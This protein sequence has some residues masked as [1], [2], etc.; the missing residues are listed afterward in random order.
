VRKLLLGLLFLVLVAPASSNM[1]SVGLGEVVLQSHLDEALRAEVPIRGA[2]AA[3]DSLRIEQASPE[4]YSR[5][6]LDRSRVPSDLN[7]EI[8]GEGADRRVVLT[9]RQAVNEPYIGILLEARWDGGRT[10]RELSLLLDPP[11]TLTAE[12][13]A[14]VV[15]EAP[16]APRDAGPAEGEVYRVRRG[17]T[18]ARVVQRMGMSGVSDDQAMIALLEHNPQ[19]FAHNNVNNLLAGAE[20]RVPP[21]S[22]LE[23]RSA[24]EARAEVAAQTE[25]WR[26]RI[27]AAREEEA[28]TEEADAEVAA[29]DEPEP[30]AEDDPADV[31]SEDVASEEAAEVAGHDVNGDASEETLAD[32]TEEPVEDRLEIVTELMPDEEAG[33]D[34][35]ASSADLL[36]ESLLSQQAEMEGLRDEIASLQEELGEREQLVEVA[37]QDLAELEDQLRQVRAEREEM[38]ARLERAEQTHNAPLHQRIT[39]DPLVMMMSVALVVLLVLAVLAFVRGGRREVVVDDRAVAPIVPV[40]GNNDSGSDDRG[41]PSGGGPSGGGAAGGVAGAAAAAGVAGAAAAVE[42][43]GEAEPKI[44]GDAAAGTEAAADATAETMAADVLA[45]VD[46]CLAY[47]M[48]DQAEEILTQNIEQDPDNHQYRLKLVEARVNLGDADGARAAAGELRER[49]GADD[50]ETRD[51]LAELETRI[52]GG[53]GDGATDGGSDAADAEAE[54]V[55][56]SGL[57]LPGASE[58]MSAAGSDA[59]TADASGDQGMQFDVDDGLD[60]ELARAAASAE[61]GSGPAQDD[62]P[63]ELAFNLDE[64][65]E[66]ELARAAASTEQGSGSAEGDAAGELAFDIDEGLDE[67]LAQA[68]A[69]TGAQQADSS[70]AGALDDLSFDL[71]DSDLPD[72]DAPKAG[73]SEAAGDDIPSLDLDDAAAFDA[74][75][76]AG[77]EGDDALDDDDNQ[78]KLSLA[79]A[80]ADMGDAE[81]ARELLD[82]VVRSGTEEQKAQAETI[83]AQIDGA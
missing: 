74:G 62:A 12:A 36:E 80:Y 24:G 58:D 8:V 34:G 21:R 60:D 50:A 40:E 61:Q 83:R 54:E 9:T 48:N 13:S 6:D 28:A 56:F 23:A 7:I 81:G 16:A 82:E 29:E 59:G 64:G 44:D 47:G 65:L 41:G 68:A 75:T 70:D 52:P 39:N 18:L 49:L 1:T 67:Q 73:A 46:V 14:P 22:A 30:R 4:A 19:A 26:E 69:D 10:M 31:A 37:N 76:D 38:Q 35:E 71:D 79:Q 3:G 57:D 32:T 33:L 45:E 66:E 15:S 63:E 72:A 77:D 51:R 78:T 27:A 17:D 25:S 42:E 55:D 11:G 5:A 43:R 53:D 2:G 20:L